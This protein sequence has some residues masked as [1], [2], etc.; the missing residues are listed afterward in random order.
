M[1]IPKYPNIDVIREAKTSRAMCYIEYLKKDFDIDDIFCVDDIVLIHEMFDSLLQAKEGLKLNS[2]IPK[3]G[4]NNLMFI[5][6]ELE[7]RFINNK[8]KIR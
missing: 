6:S 2:I 1:I 5:N 3:K 8:L 7:K 4:E